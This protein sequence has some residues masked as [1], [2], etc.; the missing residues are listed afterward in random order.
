[1]TIV[2]PSNWLANYVKQSFLGEYPVKVIHNGIDLEV[3]RNR[4]S[5]FREKHGIRED[6]FVVLGV[7]AYWVYQ[8]GTDV[9]KELSRRLE[10]GQYS[11][12]IVGGD[13][14]DMGDHIISIAR[15]D[16]PIELAEIY[17]A[18]DVFINPTREENYPTANMEAIA[19][20]IPVVT[21][22]T[23]GCAEI[24]DEMTGVAVPVDDVDAMEREIRRIH[25]DRPYS[26][27]ICMERAKR[28]EMHTQMK[29][30]IDI[31]EEL[32]RSIKAMDIFDTQNYS[33]SQVMNIA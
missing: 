24:I 33:S 25:T 21:F 17:S 3:F 16:D 6:Q 20:G 7:S 2:T 32:S 1:M 5:N 26:C 30:Y 27:D 4:K 12:V 11:I 9:F 28:F 14:E 15:V 31:Y 10:Q 22:D 13:G 29:N 8:K 18:A 19:C 23:G